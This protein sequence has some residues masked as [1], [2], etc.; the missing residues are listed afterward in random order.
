MSVS[1]L[2]RRSQEEESGRAAELF[3]EEAAEKILAKTEGMQEKTLTAE[4]EKK[5]EKRRFGRGALR[6]TAYHRALELLNGWECETVQD[7]EKQLNLFMEKGRISREARNLVNAHSIW[8]FFQS[9]LGKRLSQAVKEQQFMIGIPAREM[10]LAESEELVLIQG[11]I[12][13]YAEEEDGLLLVDYKTD[14]VENKEELFERYQ[15][16]MKYYI[17]A[18]TQVT[19]KPVKEA[20]IYSLRLQEAICCGEA[21]KDTQ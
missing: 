15:V 17:Q 13:A 11:M 6:G 10:G 9:D 18:L 1:E 20:V 14:Y 8:K 5:K 3:S 19:G 21:V 4:E 16:Q 7:V 2:K 12:D